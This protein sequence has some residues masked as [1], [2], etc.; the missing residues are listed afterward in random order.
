MIAALSRSDAKSSGLR[1][2][3]T[4]N[5]SSPSHIRCSPD[6]SL[7]PSRSA[8]TAP[9]TA[10][11]LTRRTHMIVLRASASTHVNPV[12]IPISFVPAPTYHGKMAWVLTPPDVWNQWRGERLRGVELPATG[13]EN[14]GISLTIAKIHAWVQRF[15]QSC[16]VAIQR[17]EIYNRRSGS[18]SW[19]AE[20]SNGGTETEL[21]AG[22]CV[23]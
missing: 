1:M 18:A 17:T 14:D 13:G 7:I 2:P 3:V 21:C 15:S 10:T 16:A 11:I 22:R 19:G 5:H 12:L 23:R 20:L 8:A 4:V 9:S 6:T